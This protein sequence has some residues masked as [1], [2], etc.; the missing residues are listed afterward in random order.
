MSLSAM[1]RDRDTPNGL[2]DFLVVRAIQQLGETGIE[3]LSLNF[4]AFARWLHS[5]RGRVERVLARVVRWGNPYFQIESL[6]ASTPS[7][8]RAGNRAT[9]S[10][11]GSPRCRGRRSPR[12]GSKASCRGPTP[13]PLGREANAA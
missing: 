2:T 4:A 7:S 8:S 10:T 11:T 12:S 1:R 9:C 13:A 5:P 6:F 3:E